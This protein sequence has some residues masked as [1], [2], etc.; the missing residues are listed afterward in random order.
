M[1]KIIVYCSLL[2][3][4]FNIFIENPNIQRLILSYNSGFSFECAPSVWESCYI[5]YST[6]ACPFSEACSL[7]CCCCSPSSLRGR[8]LKVITLWNPNGC[9]SWLKAFLLFL[10][11]RLSSLDAFRYTFLSKL[12][13]CWSVLC[14]DP[15]GR[16]PSRICPLAR[17]SA[18]TWCATLWANG[19]IGPDFVE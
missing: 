4:S 16:K 14:S 18:L 6:L 1:I 17:R 8:F 2:F 15:A 10:S 11:K 7:V 12:S 9:I 13:L 3:A 5:D 19:D